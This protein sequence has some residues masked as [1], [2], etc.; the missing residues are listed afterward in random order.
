MKGAHIVIPVY[1]SSLQLAELRSLEQIQLTLGSFPIC[2]VGPQ[3]LDYSPYLSIIPEAKIMRFRDDY[4]SSLKGY[5]TLLLYAGFY[6]AFEGFDYI[7]L[8]QLDVWVFEDQLDQWTG[9]Q[10]DYIGAPWLSEPPKLKR[11]N[12]LPMGK[13]MLGKVGNG[14]FSLR[15]ISSHIQIATKLSWIS[16]LFT[17]NEDFFWSI[18]VPRFYKSFRIPNMEEAVFFAF[19]L[20][21]EL[22]YEMTGHKLPFA[23]HA[24]EKHNPSF[25][26]RFISL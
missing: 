23:V 20:S 21:P 10:Y 1:K 16:W 8:T 12:L 4:F 17:K 7:L 25:W 2:F 14:G 5:N 22:A 26:K 24:W 11:I 18:V 19:E 3:S 13:W 6:K 9:L 15:K